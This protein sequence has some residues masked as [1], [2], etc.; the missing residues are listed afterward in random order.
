MA[1]Q[2]TP[3]T[4]LEHAGDTLAAWHPPT[5]MELALLPDAPRMLAA[6]TQELVQLLDGTAEGRAALRD[7]GLNPRRK[8]EEH[9]PDWA[10]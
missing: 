3:G 2:A 6:A 10:A 8:N 9:R 7:I 5:A 4:T 1:R